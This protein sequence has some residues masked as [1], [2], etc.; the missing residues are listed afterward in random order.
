MFDDRGCPFHSWRVL[1]LENSSWQREF[2]QYDV[3]QAWDAEPNLQVMKLV[4]EHRRC[5]AHDLFEPSSSQYLAVTGELTVFPCDG[6]IRLDNILD[7]PENTIFVLEVPGSSVRWSEPR[8]LTRT[9]AI[10]LLSDDSEQAPDVLTRHGIAV[11]FADGRDDVDCA[12]HCLG[13]MQTHLLQL[14]AE[15]M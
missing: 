14:R 9:E 7:G 4:G 13:N 3:S 15:K 1:V 6:G 5:P 12:S 10:E 2:K 11:V 8:D